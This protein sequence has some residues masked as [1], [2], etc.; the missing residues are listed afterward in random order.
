MFEETKNNKKNVSFSP[1][2]K[3]RPIRNVKDDYTYEEID[4][5]WYSL[6]EVKALKAET[7]LAAQQIDLLGEHQNSQVQFCQRGLE[8]VSPQGKKKA[9]LIRRRAAVAVFHAQDCEPPDDPEFIARAYMEISGYCQ[10]DATEKGTQC[11]A[12]STKERWLNECLC[13]ANRELSTSFRPQVDGAL[14]ITP[15]KLLVTCRA[16]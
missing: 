16:A 2:V 8:K 12:E 7:Y 1:E 3:V 13:S 4:S 5:T 11:F 10:I 14:E 9:L 6:K 15:E